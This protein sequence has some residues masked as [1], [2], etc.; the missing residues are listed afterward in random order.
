[1]ADKQLDVLSV[2]DVVTDAFIKLIEDQEKIEYGKDGQPDL[3]IPFG[4]KI[5]YDFSEIVA[6]VGNAANA[7]V[8]F[9]KLRLKSGL[10]SNVGSDNWGREIMGSLEDKGVDTRFVH[11]NRGHKSNYHYVLW[12]KADRTI[13]IKHEEYDYNW[14]DFRIIDIPKWIYFSSVS[15]N[16]LEYHDELAAWLESRSSVKLAF[17][18]GTFQIKAGAKRLKKVYER[19]EIL[20]VNREEATTI[21][22]GNHKDIHELLDKLHELGPKTVLISDGPAGAYASDGTNRYK[23]PIYPDPK[24]PYDR[25]GAGDAFTS[26]FV[27]AVMKGAD[28]AGAL[29]W[30]PINAMSVVQKVGAQAGLLT[31]RE[32]E[33]YLRI[34]PEDYHPVRLR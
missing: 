6:G 5:P 9:T 13:L 20:A 32:I 16:A 25:T 34:A 1:M 14:P 3:S 18:P 28:I 7:S 8:V 31:E 19:T 22:S 33:H 15:E 2:G 29:L 26:T 24:P 4:T 30:A 23:M 27:A 12:Y 10:V 17:Q 11:I 21:S